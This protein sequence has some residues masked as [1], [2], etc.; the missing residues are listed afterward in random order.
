MKDKK[1]LLLLFMHLTLV[2]GIIIGMLLVMTKQIPTL[3]ELGI[4][5]L[6]LIGFL[7]E[8]AIVI[9]GLKIYDIKVFPKHDSKNNKNK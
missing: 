4:R 1:N 3:S 7:C 2:I 8:V 9:V 5:I 6:G